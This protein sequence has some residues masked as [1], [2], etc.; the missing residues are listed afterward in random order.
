MDNRKSV[1]KNYFVHETGS[2]EEKCAIGDGTQIW[3]FSR[4][5]KNS[6]IGKN[7]NIGQNV[8]V[9][10]DG[11]IGDN[12]KIQNNVSLYKG[13]ILESNVFCGPSCVFTNVVNPRSKIS[14]KDQFQRTLVKE[15]ATI[16]ANA[17][18]LCGVTIGK[19][20]FIGAGAV[21]TK[22]VP[23]YGLVY[24]NPATLNGWVCECGNKL[25]ENNKCLVCEKTFSSFD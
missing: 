14:R 9:G 20:A 19:Y 17:T 11:K 23:D 13:V 4:V 8:V 16:G 18:I 22:D 12:A 25:N 6:S 1:K 7:V 5:L 3:N 24:G 10:P 2:I 15:G 21:V